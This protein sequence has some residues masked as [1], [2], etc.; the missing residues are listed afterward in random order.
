MGWV[1]EKKG[2]EEERGVDRARVAIPSKESKLFQ[3]DPPGLCSR[4]ALWGLAGSTRQTGRE[5]I[6]QRWE[7]RVILSAH[8]SMSISR[9]KPSPKSKTRN[10]PSHKKD[11]PVSSHH[12]V[13]SG[14]PAL[15][16]TPR[17][18]QR[19]ASILSPTLNPILT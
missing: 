16:Q 7:K 13:L 12:V 17:P 10:Q 18:T 6:W 3:P 11:R 1:M 4:Y 19:F 8:Q 14:S 15:V 2:M 9:P 5:G